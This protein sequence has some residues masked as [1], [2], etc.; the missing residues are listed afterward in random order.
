MVKAL[1]LTGNTYGRLTVI[2]RATYE[3]KGKGTRWLCRCTCGNEQVYSGG[4]LNAG[5]GGTG[6]K[7]CRSHGGTRTPE[8]NSWRGMRER[9]LNPNHSSYHS[10]GG[11]GI[12]VCERW[13]H[14]FENF[15]DDMGERPK[16]HS[17]DRIDNDKGYSPE[18]CRWATARVQ[19]HNKEYPVLTDEQISAILK[20]LK[21]GSSQWDLA[22]AIGISRGHMANIAT[23]H[24]RPLP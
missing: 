23:G 11:R 20:C 22:T 10:Y 3:E 9:C 7:K 14:S 2:E 19:A 21:S 16:G 4:H 18:N 13:L 8:Y 5:R 17:L 15:R 12:G 1:E 24:S 6:C